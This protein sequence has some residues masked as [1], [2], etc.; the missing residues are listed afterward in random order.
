M[1][2]VGGLSCQLLE[3]ETPSTEQAKSVAIHLLCQRVR[4]H[5]QSKQRAWPYSCVRGSDTINRASK[6]RGHTLVVSEGQ[7]PSTEQAKSVAI[8]LL[9][10]R[11][12]HHQQSKQREWPYSCVRGSDTINRASKESGH[13]V[14]SE[15]ETAHEECG[16][17]FTDKHS[18]QSYLRRKQETESAAGF[19]QYRAGA[20]KINALT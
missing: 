15:G 4:H 6:E 8:H 17:N 9:C 13:T 19:T 7:T 1:I 14:V 18:I 3:E 11:V 16:L 2:R 12:R 5:Q 10:Q 20:H